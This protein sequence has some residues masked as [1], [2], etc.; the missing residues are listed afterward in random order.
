MTTPTRPLSRWHWQNWPVLVKLIGVLLVPTVVA[1]VVGALRIVDQAAAAPGFERII[2][3]VGVQQELSGVVTA[4]QDERDLAAAYIAGGRQAG[5][6]ELEAQFGAVDTAVSTARAGVQDVAGI[7]D[8]GYLVALGRLGGL[9]PLRQSVVGTG[10]ADIAVSE[11]G[12]AIDPLLD[13]DAALARGGVDDAAV[14][15][16]VA[17]L[18]ALLSAREQVA[19]QHALLSPALIVDELNPAT[20]EDVRAAGVRLQTELGTA[21]TALSPDA[22]ARFLD[23]I[24]G[25]PEQGRQRIIA[26]VF[27]RQLAGEPPA[28]PP[29]D[30][31]ARTAAMIEPMVAAEQALRDEVTATATALR[32]DARAAAGLNSVLLLVAL[33]VGVV[34]SFVIARSMLR[35]LGVLRRS[36]LDVADTRLP[37]A[38][39]S[40]RAGSMPADVEP[41]QVHT[42]EEIGQV[43]RAFDAVHTQAVRLAAEQA[44]LRANVNDMFVNL[45]R[46]SQGLVQRQLKLIDRLE[47]SEESPEALDSLFQLDH[48]ATRMRRN[49]ENLLVLAGTESA[50]RSG[51]P[52]PLVDVLRAA[53][54]EVEQYQRLVL[55]PPPDVLVLGKPAGDLVHL[56]AEL[57]DNATLFSPPDS[58]VMISA[59]V[60]AD[61]PLV[62]DVDDRGVGMGDAELADANSRLATSPTVDASVSRRMGLFV[63]GRLAA[64]H[65]IGVT[66]RRGHDGVGVTAAIALP[67][68]LVRATDA[69]D[70]MD[71]AAVPPP[72][73]PGAWQR[74]PELPA[75]LNGNGA[76]AANGI[77]RNGAGGLGSGAV[78]D[79]T[80]DHP[81]GSEPTPELPRRTP[82][83]VAPGPAVV[84]P[85][86]SVPAPQPTGEQA[87]SRDLFRSAQREGVEHTPLGVTRVTQ[88]ATLDHA[89][90][91]FDDVASAWFKENKPVP[92][93]WSPEGEA[94][95][96]SPVP[97]AATTEQAETHRPAADWGSA[98]AGWQAAE[99]LTRSDVG[100]VTPA[101]LPRRQPKALLVPGA[102]ESVGAAGTAA[103]ARS[104]EAVRGRLASYQRGV[105]EG[106][107]VRREP[108]A[109]QDEQHPTDE[110]T[111]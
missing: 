83:R 16:Q 19:R 100:E 65:E 80:P 50:T 73:D 55:Q 66:V 54:S 71:A 59:T 81:L 5:R 76:V 89:T 106:R 13:A 61:G 52:V 102:A 36:A 26:L 84:P 88:R 49:S 92:V 107:Q 68:R 12:A 63:V 3:V 98:D 4:I 17:A 53:V 48:L 1:L 96:P 67:A 103:P 23:T 87:G 64:R 97:G 8:S 99:A 22:R 82:D 14:S 42:S 38:V 110:E 104:A 40:V 32:D 111:Q 18:H 58:Q 85:Q 29:A 6:A 109:E 34:V 10:P 46:R 77:G 27:G 74:T 11:Y 94:A 37:A 93:H 33:A 15:G 21:S 91:I 30:W 95:E 25:A 45:S 20:V 72:P 47:T 28:T 57:L 62:I 86:P 105:Q 2:D 90:P 56:L 70:E 43:A 60:L 51:R 75:A 7:E 9:F 44:Q 108:D 31:D 101:G 79:W 24:T 69:V 78:S 35:P 39:A 41:V